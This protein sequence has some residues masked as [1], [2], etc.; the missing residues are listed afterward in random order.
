M[1]VTSI[2]TVILALLFLSPLGPQE[3]TFKTALGA[4]FGVANWVIAAGTGDYFG[5]AAERNPM[6]HT[7]SLA[8]EEQ[9]YLVLPALMLLTL[10]LGAKISKRWGWL[11]PFSILGILAVVSLYSVRLGTAFPLGYYGPVTRA[12]EFLAGCLLALVIAFVRRLP[13]ILYPLL[14]LAGLALMLWGLLAI[15]PETPFPGKWTLVPVMATLLPIVAGQGGPEHRLRRAVHEAH[16]CDRR[17]VVLTLP[18]ALAVHRG[19]EGHLAVLW[20]GA[21]AGVGVRTA[22]R[23]L[24]DV[25]DAS[26]FPT[27]GHL[28]A[29]AGL[30]PVTHRSGT[31]IRGEFPARSGNKHL[32]RALF[33]SVKGH[34]FLPGGG[35]ETCPVAVTRCARWWPWDLPLGGCWP[36]TSVG[37]WVSARGSP[38]GRRGLG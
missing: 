37:A 19:G 25:G 12:W 5:T 10:G 24:L 20:R 28:A 23:I 8:V 18:L 32:K 16:G 2:A 9:F 26:L 34:W 21:H 17:L 30:A 1:A 33:L 29:Y 7:W 13:R 4:T 27:A 15:T 11:V 36:S 14:G 6:L 22:A 31:S 35:H 3:T 38:P